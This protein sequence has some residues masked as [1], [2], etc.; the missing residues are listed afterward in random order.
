MHYSKPKRLKPRDYPAQQEASVGHETHESEH[1]IVKR[2]KSK[3]ADNEKWLN[4]VADQ[5]WEL[6]AASGETDWDV[7]PT[8][9]FRR[10]RQNRWGSP[11]GAKLGC[12]QVVHGQALSLDR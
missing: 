1:T 3:N 11:C 9:W 7:R 6:V 2:P 8:F 10:P 12:A 4:E 5:G